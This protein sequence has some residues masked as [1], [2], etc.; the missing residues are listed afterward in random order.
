M[1]ECECGRG[2]A[3]GDLHEML[4]K[5]MI[6]TTCDSDCMYSVILYMY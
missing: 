6:D 2:G 3:G 4:Q 1:C 5:K